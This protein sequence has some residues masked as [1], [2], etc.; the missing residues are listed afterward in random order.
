MRLPDAA[1]L[2]LDQLRSMEPRA[3]TADP[4]EQGFIDAI[5]DALIESDT[6]VPAPLLANFVPRWGDPALIL[7]SRLS[8]NEELLLMLREGDLSRAQWTAVNNLLLRD[9]SARFFAANLR[10]LVVRHEFDVIDPD[11]PALSGGGSGGTSLG[12]GVRMLPRGFPPIAVYQLTDLAGENA[13]LLVKGP[14][15]VYYRRTVIPTNTQIGWGTI[16]NRIDRQTDLRQYLTAWNHAD[17]D[18]TRWIFDA[19]TPIRWHDEKSFEANVDSALHAQIMG[20]EEFV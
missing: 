8:S 4:V 6:K 5:F 3:A 11:V 2:L 12:C 10:E 9:R 17:P 19:V 16:V 14:R 20:L 18:K 7:L 15:D 13:T 1:P